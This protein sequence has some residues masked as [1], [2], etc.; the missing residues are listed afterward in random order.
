M[1]TENTYKI[2]KYTSP[3]GGVYIGQ[4]KHSLKVR[5]HKDGSAYLVIDKNTGK[6]KQEAIAKAI[7]KYG[8]DN[9]K[10]EVL[11]ENLTLD[12][13]NEKEAEM[14]KY[15][16]S[17][18]KCYNIADGGNGL[19]GVNETKI[20]QYSLNGEL[21]KEYESLQEATEELG[22]LKSAEANIS[23][24]CKGRKHRAYGYIWRYSDS[25]LEVKPL[26]RYRERICQFDLDMN[27]IATYNSIE[28]AHKRTGVG[29]T[30]IGNA[31][32]G[33]SKMAGGFLWK[34]EKDYLDKK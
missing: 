33:W 31:L 9:F 27:Y 21:I 22:L 26:K 8:W 28:E 24:C 12:E 32:N 13:A 30:S 5:G 18:G 15:Y 25:D 1:D 20:K 2:Y 14:I 19:I 7:I 11:F 6:Y 23:A 3:S 4:T 10:K 16:R 34:F 29:S 17:I